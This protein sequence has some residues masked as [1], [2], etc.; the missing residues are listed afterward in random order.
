MSSHS[1]LIVIRSVFQPTRLH[2]HVKQDENC[3]AQRLFDEVNWGVDLFARKMRK[4][5]NVSRLLP[6]HQWKKGNC[7]L[8]A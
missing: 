2:V 7:K 1:V 6:P 5:P 3:V 8:C 4:L